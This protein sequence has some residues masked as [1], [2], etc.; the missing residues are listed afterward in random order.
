VPLPELA[1]SA[2]TLALGFPPSLE[3]RMAAV[4]MGRYRNDEALASYFKEL[5]QVETEALLELSKGPGSPSAYLA[6]SDLEEA[7]LGGGFSEVITSWV[8][9]LKLPMPAEV[10]GPN[11]L[12]LRSRIVDRFKGLTFGPENP[13]V[14]ENDDNPGS[15]LAYRLAKWGRADASKVTPGNATLQSLISFSFESKIHTVTREVY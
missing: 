8:I 15:P 7:P 5:E 3:E 1:I 11:V 9:L 10:K 12:A 14:I 2:D 13:G 4:L 6:F